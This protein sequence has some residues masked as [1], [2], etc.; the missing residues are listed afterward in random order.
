MGGDQMETTNINFRTD[1]SLKREADI[2]FSQ[3]GMNMTTALNIFLKTTVRAG[4]LPF[5]VAGDDY[6]LRQIIR[7]KLDEAQQEANKPNAKY[8]SHDEVFGGL[9]EKY[10]L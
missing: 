1:A 7:E 5:D 8:L 10:G 6:A 2:L 9:R 4:R 3:M